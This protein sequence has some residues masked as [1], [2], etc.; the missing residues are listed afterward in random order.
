MGKHPDHRRLLNGQAIGTS[1]TL[2]ASRTANM[3]GLLLFLGFFGVYFFLQ[4]Y[5]LPK[6]GIST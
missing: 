2:K 6:L 4:L 3:K 1:R 5:L